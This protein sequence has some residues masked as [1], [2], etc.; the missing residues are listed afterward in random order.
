MSS[1]LVQ[2][3]SQSINRFCSVSMSGCDRIK[4]VDVYD[5]FQRFA[6]E[7][8]GFVNAAVSFGSDGRAN[9]CVDRASFFSMLVERIPVRFLF[10]QPDQ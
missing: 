2:Q 3:Q 6:I 7:S 5:A 9:L 8:D 10:G 4:F 1:A